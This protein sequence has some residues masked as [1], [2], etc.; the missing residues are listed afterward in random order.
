MFISAISCVLGPNALWCYNIDCLCV[1]FRYH[2][3]TFASCNLLPFSLAYI[4]LCYTFP[5]SF[6]L[7]I[8]LLCFQARCR[9]RRINLGSNLSWFIFSCLFVFDDLYFVDLVVIGLVLC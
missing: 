8:A 3:L 1:C 5:L 7:R 2:L 4:F 6:P 9:R